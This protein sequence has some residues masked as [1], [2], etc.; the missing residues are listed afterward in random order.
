MPRK[1]NKLM[2]KDSSATFC[3]EEWTYLSEADIG[4]LSVRFT[5]V[6]QRLLTS[7][8]QSGSIMLDGDDSLTE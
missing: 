8:P 6:T 3:L 5:A 4:D 2:K 7:G 1:I